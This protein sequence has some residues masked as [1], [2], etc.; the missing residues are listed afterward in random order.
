MSSHIPSVVLGKQPELHCYRNFL[1]TVLIVWGVCVCQCSTHGIQKKLDLLELEEAVSC[2]TSAG[3]KTVSL[4]QHY[5]LL[6]AESSLQGPTTGIIT[7][8]N[9]PPLQTAMFSFIEQNATHI[10]PLQ[11]VLSKKEKKK[12]FLKQAL[13]TEHLRHKYSSMFPNSCLP[14]CHTLEVKH[15]KIHY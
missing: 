14:R 6:T 11:L 1:N 8:S 7:K 4:P 12:K 9:S 15:L 5:T 2:L 10:H 3:N 13:E